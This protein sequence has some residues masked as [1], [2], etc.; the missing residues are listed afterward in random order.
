MFAASAMISRALWVVS[1]KWIA[2]EI[3][4]I[5]LIILIIA[6]VLSGL[7]VLS[8][9]SVIPV[10]RHI[11]GLL[12]VI[13][14]HVL[15]A[16]LPG[17]AVISILTVVSVI[18]GLVIL[19]AVLSGLPVLSVILIWA[20]LPLLSCLAETAI[21]LIIRALNGLPIVVPNLE[22]QW[23]G[24]A[25]VNFLHL[26]FRSNFPNCGLFLRI[27]RGVIIIVGADVILVRNPVAAGFTFAVS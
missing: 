21:I 18:I 3:L 8:V 5:G 19:P 6:A 23:F 24:A 26:D 16:V 22:I 12:I 2:A 27:I 7:S 11:I 14:P 25:R 20:V 4:V 13:L 9:L 15:P 17:L 1:V 10:I